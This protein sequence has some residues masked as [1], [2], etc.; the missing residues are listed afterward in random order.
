MKDQTI[1]SS[2]QQQNIN[3]QEHKKI[4]CMK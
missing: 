2:H 4:C 1:L 3:N